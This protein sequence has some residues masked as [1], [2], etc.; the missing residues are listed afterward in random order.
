MNKRNKVCLILLAVLVYSQGINA[1]PDSSL[2]FGID[3]LSSI[4]GQPFIVFNLGVSDKFTVGIQS[5]VAERTFTASNNLGSESFEA[6]KFI[7]GPRVQYFFNGTF[8]DS[9]YLSGFYNHISFNGNANILPGEVNLRGYSIG[10]TGGYF[11]NWSPWFLQL[12]GGIE[13]ERVESQLSAAANF[14]G[15]SELEFH[16][17]LFLGLSF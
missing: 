12:G 5:G 6:D 2:N 4:F 1:A 3:P 7:I 11:W 17:E 15:Y 10:A 16:L 8:S 9:F 13:N 14:E